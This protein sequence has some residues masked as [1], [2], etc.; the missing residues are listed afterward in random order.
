MKTYQL[1]KKILNRLAKELDADIYRWVEVN[2][3]EPGTGNH[4]VWDFIHVHNLDYTVS[5]ISS[6]VMLI[7]KHGCNLYF[8]LGQPLRILDKYVTPDFFIKWHKD[9][10]LNVV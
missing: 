3:W 2:K 5:Y 4:Y 6:D 9:P 10:S 1:S 8:T 7:R